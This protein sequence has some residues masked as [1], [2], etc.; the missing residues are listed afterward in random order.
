MQNIRFIRSPAR[1]VSCAILLPA[2]V[3]VS[4]YALFANYRQARL[5]LYPWMAISAAALSWI[6]GRYL[7]P[8]WLRWLV[9]SWSLAL[10][11]L[12]TIA[13]CLSGLLPSH[14]AYALV[15]AQASA[16][17]VWAILGPVGWQWRL[18][19]VLPAV[20][21]IV[22]FCRSFESW[23][24]DQW[25][26]QMVVVAAIVIL[27]CGILRLRGFTLRASMNSETPASGPPMQLHQFGV[28]HLLIWTAALVPIL[29]VLRGIDFLNFLNVGNSGIFPFALLVFDIAIVNM[30]VIW[31]I[32]GSGRWPIRL[33]AL[34]VIPPVLATGVTA[35][36]ESL[37]NGGAS[38]YDPVV[39]DIAQSSLSWRTWLCLDAAFLAAMLLFLLAGG[40]RLARPC[41]AN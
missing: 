30:V 27:L 4:N 32:L 9:F 5:L 15:S 25:K 3:A 36:M 23:S 7:S 22:L 33:G 24:E 14:F 35:Y 19:T 31:S 29:I 11:D 16:L 39:Y 13:A 37:Y 6:V 18:P 2:A 17:T 38:R 40:Y 12:L 10:L 34:L 20:A 1:F 28:K 8:A 26:F 41:R 21:I